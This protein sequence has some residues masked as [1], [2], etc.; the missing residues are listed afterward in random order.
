MIPAL[1]KDYISKISDKTT[2]T[3]NRQFYY[4]TLLNIKAVIEDAIKEYEKERH[5]KK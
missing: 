2:T 4:S 1:I 5:F 3:E